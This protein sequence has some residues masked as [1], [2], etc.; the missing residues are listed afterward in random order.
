MGAKCTLE[1]SF[2][3]SANL[4]MNH[5]Y[6]QRSIYSN[7]VHEIYSLIVVLKCISKKKYELLLTL[8]ASIVFSSLPP[9]NGKRQYLFFQVSSSCCLSLLSGTLRRITEMNTAVRLLIGGSEDCVQ[10]EAR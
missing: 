2:V 1:Y 5:I 7:D 4:F 6:I 10:S 8:Q 9:C 3:G